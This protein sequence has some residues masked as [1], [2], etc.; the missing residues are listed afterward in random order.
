M[1]ADSRP[2]LYLPVPHMLV[3][4]AEA[5]MFQIRDGAGVC[6][7]VMTAFR[8]G[9]PKAYSDCALAVADPEPGEGVPRQL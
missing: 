1:Q 9:L 3:P 8:A 6:P 2:H 7:A 5:D 4:G